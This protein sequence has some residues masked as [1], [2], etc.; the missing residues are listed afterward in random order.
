MIIEDLKAALKKSRAVNSFYKKQIKPLRRQ[1]EPEIYLVRALRSQNIDTVIDVGANTGD[2]AL[3]FSRIARRVVAFEPNPACV[4]E[5]EDLKL[6]NVDVVAAGLS[7]AA[8]SLELN[9]P[10]LNG[11]P[12]TGEA[13]IGDVADRPAHLDYKRF[14]IDVMRFDDYWKSAP[15]SRIDLVKIDIEGHELAMLKGAS[16]VIERYAPVLFVE[17]ESRHNA[18]WRAVFDF[19]G[20]RGDEFFYSP[21]GVNLKPT[22]ADDLPE[23]QETFECRPFAR[24]EAKTYINNFIFINQ[25]PGVA[26]DA[27]HKV[28][29]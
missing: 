13:F 25:R 18:A 28:V 11:K 20:E 4:R 12:I 21:N 3:E 10:T 6:A 2:Y 1:W 26:G 5:V 16:E 9:V 15:Q 29:V 24:G 7:G 23:L 17:I 19:L 14:A 22:R 8:G 27:L